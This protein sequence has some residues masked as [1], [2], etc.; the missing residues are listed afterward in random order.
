MNAFSRV[1]F[2]VGIL[3]SSSGC[4]EQLNCLDCNTRVLPIEHAQVTVTVKG[5]G[6]LIA[7]STQCMDLTLDTA[8]IAT[9][10]ALGGALV[11]PVEFTSRIAALA[12]LSAA[13]DTGQFTLN[14]QPLNSSTGTVQW[15]RFLGASGLAGTRL[16]WSQNIN[17]VLYSIE[18]NAIELTAACP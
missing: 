3:G 11:V 10:T 7:E 1:I 14:G 12:T 13:Y 18:M 6:A 16:V 5:N 2:A 15:S 17:S 4:L 8:Q 9:F